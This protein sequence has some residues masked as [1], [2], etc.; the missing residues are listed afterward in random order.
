MFEF[1][2][3]TQHFPAPREGH[4]KKA[5]VQ[6]GKWLNFEKIDF[7]VFYIYIV[8]IWGGITHLHMKQASQKVDQHKIERKE[9]KNKPSDIN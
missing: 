1:F 3:V 2:V 5:A 6:D 7:F 8:K 9:R 4:S